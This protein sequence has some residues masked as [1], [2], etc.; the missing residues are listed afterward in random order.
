M[1]GRC[2]L[3]WSD[4][5]V[6]PALRVAASQAPRLRV[7]AGP[8]TGKTFAMMR[9]IARILEEGIPPARILVST[10][11]RVAAA[12]L[13]AELV[14][15][16]V[17]GA[18]KVVATTIHGLCFSILQ[19]NTVL[20][21]TGR[22]PRPLLEYEARF[23]LED[24]KSDSFG[25][26]PER[27]KRLRAYEG[28]WARLQTDQPGWPVDRV[29]RDFQEALLDWLKFHRAMLIGELVPVALRYLRD[30]PAARELHEFRRILVDEYQDLN[31]AEQGLIDILAADAELTIVGDEDQSIYSF[32]FAHPEGIETFHRKH[33]GTVDESL[34]VCRRC[35]TWIV[36]LAT[37]LIASRSGQSRRALSPHSDNGRGEVQIVQWTSAKSEARGLA[38]FTQQRISEGAH[39]GGILVLATSRKFGYGIRDELNTL[40]IRALSFFREQALDGNPKDPER[41]RQQEAMTLLEL[42]SNPTDAVALRSWCGF[43]SPSL[44]SAAWTRIVDCSKQNRLSIQAVLDGIC[45]GQINLAYV[46]P[47]RDRMLGLRR[48]LERLEGLTGQDLVDE[49]FPDDA[50]FQDLRELAAE[51]PEECS[52]SVLLDT[53]RTGITQPELP[54]DVDYIRVMSLHKSKGLTADIVIVAGCVEGLLPRIDPKLSQAE[55]DAELREQRRLFYVALTRTRQTL[56]LSSVT[57]MSRQDAHSLGIEISGD[58]WF[59]STITSRFIDELG[60]SRPRSIIGTSLR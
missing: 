38:Q 25:D 43:G 59:A 7:R 27:R 31:A 4:G 20:Q 13:K 22:N 32:K 28:A 54:T 47:I 16:N 46:S 33:G 49:L 26:I 21:R 60:P 40:G 11:T 8:G 58:G 50:A 29:D 17:A 39:P 34:S 37:E 30:N 18:D 51:A 1:Q 3:P 10:F 42:A 57:R 14:R 36:E 15:L 5:L 19:K 2:T 24:L 53:M 44:R 56:I 9:R 12:D 52:A 41:S 35:P 45:E 23:L 48:R 55:Q 6:G